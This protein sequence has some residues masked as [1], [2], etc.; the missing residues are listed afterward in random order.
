MKKLTKEQ[1]Y[2]INKKGYGKTIEAMEA[3]KSM[4]VG[5]ACLITFKEWTVKSPL[6]VYLGNQK[7]A[8]GK[9][10]KTKTLK[11]IRS[12]AVMRIK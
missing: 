3:L 4:Q 5:D 10:W 11:K 9:M 8:T 7:K 12:W 1:F 6:G 2:T